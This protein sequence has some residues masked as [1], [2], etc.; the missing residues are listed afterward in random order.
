MSNMSDL[1]G[2]SAAMNL[3]S[4]Q[5]ALMWAKEHLPDEEYTKIKK[6]YDKVILYTSIF[7]IVCVIPL[8]ILFINYGMNAVLTPDA[9]P[10]GAV[11]YVIAQAD[12]DGNFFWTHDS[13]KYE[14]PLEDYGLSPDDYQ[15][16]DKFKVYVNDSQDVISISPVED[17]ASEKEIKLGIGIIGALVVPT[18]ITMCIYI[19]IAWNTFGKP[20]R[21][22][23]KKLREEGKKKSAN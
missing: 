19:P 23:N 9:M 13:V 21:E 22:F 10:A 7:V 4:H 8:V 17:K 11:D 16:R 15:F 18:L 3:Q 5:F 1:L 6:S 2:A 12:Y 20:W 14:Q